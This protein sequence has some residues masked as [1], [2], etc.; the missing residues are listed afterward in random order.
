MIS[1][2]LFVTAIHDA[3][4]AANDSLMEKNTGILDKYFV[5]TSD[6]GELKSSLDK[7][8][9]TT[10][11]IVSKKGNVSHDDF[12][13][14]VDALD[15]ARKALSPGNAEGKTQGSAQIPG[16]LSPKSVVIEYPHQTTDGIEFVE[17]HVPLITLVPLA[18]SQIEKATLS[19]N[20]EMEIVD[21][22]LQLNFS[23]K[24]QTRKRR[25]G[26]TTW[27]K[28]EI[29]I[30]PQEPSEGLKQLVEGYEQALKGQIP[31]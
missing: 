28:L 23:T 5:D 30:S 26:N 15:N 18:M 17:V 12:K 16:T 4:L 7:A 14:A 9:Q 21:S 29:T 8:L 19:A 25:K 27:G 11:N 6:E 22:E 20:F 31:H 10:Q 13:A 24:E 3:I 2:K 1:L